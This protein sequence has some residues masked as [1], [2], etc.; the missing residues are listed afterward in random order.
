MKILIRKDA[1]RKHLIIVGLLVS[2]T[3]ASMPGCSG[4]PG[5]QSAR[6][7]DL[8]ELR[9]LL[10]RES[11]RPEQVR[12]LAAETLSREVIKAKDREDREFI[13][14]LRSCAAPLQDALTERG[15]LR[16]GVGAEAQLLLLESGAFKGDPNQYAED[17]DG[18]WRAISAR[19][20]LNDGE[21]RRRYF[22]DPDERVR[23]AALLAAAEVN[24]EADVAELLE[25]SRVDP[26]PL[27]R[28]RAF[29]SLAQIGGE[30]VADALVDRFDRADEES[31]L[32]I[33]DAWSS[34]A[35]YG[36][37]GRRQLTRLLSHKDGYPSLHA[38]ALLCADPDEAVKN[39]GMTRLLRFSEQG[40][41]EERRVALRLLPGTEA[42]TTQA[43]VKAT[44]A[45]DLDVAIIAWARLLQSPRHREASLQRLREWA[46]SKDP[47]A[48]QA[49]AAISTLGDSAILPLMRRQSTDEDPQRRLLAGGALLRLR[50]FDDIALLLA[51]ED[52]HVRRSIACRVVAEPYHPRFDETDH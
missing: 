26:D 13:H 42:R 29:Q 38:A 48:Y 44:K 36:I 10:A 45:E 28:R 21:A 27:C 49:R 6:R 24:D 32:A 35:L 50:S 39:Q 3:L 5:I 47:L 19:S 22:S 15:Q 9:K 23:R 18:A 34:K 25:V 20:R 17:P 7:G 31:K 37:R 8:Q 1:P 43:L 30:R 12:R 11:L 2:F 14:S 40:T 41:P 46:D 52:I 16:D 4:G 33:V 51:D